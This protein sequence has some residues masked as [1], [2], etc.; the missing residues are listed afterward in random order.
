[1]GLD[2]KGSQ[3]SSHIDGKASMSGR[4][5]DGLAASSVGI[6]EFVAKSADS[7]HNRDSPPEDCL[8]RLFRMLIG[9]EIQGACC[10]RVQLRQIFLVGVRDLK[11]VEY[12][13][14]D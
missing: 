2:Q 5:F 6:T 14:A 3:C 11:V 8:D 12:P 9:R 7:V 10:H 1:M 13:L 4:R